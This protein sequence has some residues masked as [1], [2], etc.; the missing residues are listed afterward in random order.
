MLVV[1]TK[2]IQDIIE[3]TAWFYFIGNSL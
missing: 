3:V 2:V 1:F